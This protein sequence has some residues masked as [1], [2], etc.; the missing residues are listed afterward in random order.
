MA[1]T[2][3]KLPKGEDIHTYFICNDWHTRELCLKTYN[4]FKKVAKM[5]PRSQRRLVINGDFIDAP[6]FFGKKSDLKKIAKNTDVLEMIIEECD[7]EIQ[8]GNDILDEMQKYFDWIYFI[9]GNHCWRYRNFCENYSPVQYQPHFN[10][11]KRLGLHDRGIPFVKYNDWL[12]ITHGMFHSSTHLKK[13]LDVA[14]GQNV[15]YGHLHK[16]EEKAFPARGETLKA[17]SIPAMCTLNPEYLKNTETNWSNGFA[18]V[19]M[20]SNGKFT[21]YVHEI[22]DGKL[23]LPNGKMIQG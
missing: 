17:F 10:Y 21:K 8:W 13:H 22:T 5:V 1:I 12:D 7:A 19:N 9:E 15:C 2:K 20:M 16:Y 3:V 23:I 4:I 11:V 6:M 18:Q 14:K